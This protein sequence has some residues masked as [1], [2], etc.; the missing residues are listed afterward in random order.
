MMI[1]LYSIGCPKCNVLKRKLDENNIEYEYITDENVMREKGIEILPVLE[2]D[3]EMLNY[4][5]A[6]KWLKGRN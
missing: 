3:G 1:K 4:S 6:A 5:G 2:V